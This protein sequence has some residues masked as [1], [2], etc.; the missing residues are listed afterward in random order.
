MWHSWGT[1]EVRAGVLVSIPEGK[2]H[3][4]DLDVDGK[5]IL[6]WIFKSWVGEVW[7][8]LLWLRIGKDGGLLRLRQ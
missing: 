6:K 4:E 3:L 5:T 1:G 2:K 7:T 8:C